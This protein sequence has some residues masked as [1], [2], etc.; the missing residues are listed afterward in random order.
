MCIRDRY[1]RTG[2]TSCICPA[3]YAAI[4]L[5]NIFEMCRSQVMRGFVKTMKRTRIIF[6]RWL[7]RY[8]ADE[9]TLTVCTCFCSSIIF[10]GCK[11]VEMEDTSM[12]VVEEKSADG[13]GSGNGN[14]A[15]DTASQD[16][17]DDI[18]TPVTTQE[19]LTPPT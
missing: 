9:L 3:F 7:V 6:V 17:D 13:N 15:A 10:A 2:F 4:L 19:E 8:G 1:I 5:I 14:G 12:D 16:D 11:Q 18:E